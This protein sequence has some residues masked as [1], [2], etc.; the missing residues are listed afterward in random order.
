MANVQE[1]SMSGYPDR[2]FRN[3]LLPNGMVF[4]M[5]NSTRSDE[6]F[7]QLQ[8]GESLALDLIESG[9]VGTFN[10]NKQDATVCRARS[11]GNG[12]ILP[13][14]GGGAFG[15]G[16]ARYGRAPFSASMDAFYGGGEFES[17]AFAR[18]DEKRQVG[19]ACE[20]DFKF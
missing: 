16:A 12:Y 5:R 6:T 17:T 13:Y 15:A 19:P 7:D 18:L 9:L 20:L 10:L 14:R 4:Q 3:I 2:V 1:T 11:Y 8:G